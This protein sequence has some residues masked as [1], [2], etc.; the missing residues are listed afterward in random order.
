LDGQQV[1][2]YRNRKGYWGLI[3]QVACDSNAKV[4]FVQTDWPGATNDLS[5]FK[6]TKIYSLLRSNLLPDW[7][8]IVADEAY[9]PLSVECGHQIL[10]P[11]SQ[12]QLN[13]AK[14]EDWQ[15]LQDWQDRVTENSS[16]NIEKPIPRYW[17]MRAFNHELSSERITVERVLGMLVRRFG[18]LWKPIE[19]H[20]NKVPT[21]FRVLCKL[22]NICMDRWL[23]N[24]PTDARLGRYSCTK[25]PSFS[26]YDYLWSNFDTSVGLDDSFE[27]PPDDL[28]FSHLEN[29][30]QNLNNI[31]SYY[32][33]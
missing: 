17:K 11:F 24:N 23:L 16:L 33:S 5:C 21:I 4:R 14:K 22:H 25:S 20:I 2:C 10:T 19:Y 30:F 12:H 32:T 31:C 18:I 8:H 27:Q 1:G 7:M 29:R 15:N 3:S 28:V 26:N 13:T 6:E 9:S